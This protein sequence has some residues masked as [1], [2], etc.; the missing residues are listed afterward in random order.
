MRCTPS[1]LSLLSGIRNIVVILPDN[2]RSVR[3][4]QLSIW[5]IGLFRG[6]GAGCHAVP[7][8][9]VGR[10]VCTGE[11]GIGGAGYIQCAV[12]VHSNPTLDVVFAYVGMKTHNVRIEEGARCFNTRLRRTNVSLY[13]RM[14]SPEWDELRSLREAGFAGTTSCPAELRNSRGCSLNVVLSS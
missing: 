2:C 4:R 9:T 13:E 8:I 11:V 7:Q 3:N 1:T 10:D 12:V 5:K 14:A 6:V